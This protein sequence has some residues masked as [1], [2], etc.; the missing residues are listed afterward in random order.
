MEEDQENSNEVAPRKRIENNTFGA[1]VLVGDKYEAVQF[2]GHGLQWCKG[3][4]GPTWIAIL[5]NF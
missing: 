5:T 4:H 2:L 3:L 1:I